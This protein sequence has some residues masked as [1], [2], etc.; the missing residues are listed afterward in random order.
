M[1]SQRIGICLWTELVKQAGRALYVCEKERDG[2]RWK[3][4]VHLCAHDATS[5]KSRYAP[6][7]SDVSHAIHG[8]SRPT[9]PSITKSTGL[10]MAK[11]GLSGHGA[12]QG[13]VLVCRYEA[14]HNQPA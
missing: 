4:P 10:A 14:H 12:A 11:G 6:R 7:H 1:V 2:A 8:A 3:L 5:R 13:G 9:M